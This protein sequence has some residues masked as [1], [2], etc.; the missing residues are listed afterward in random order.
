[1]GKIHENKTYPRSQR[2]NEWLF[3]SYVI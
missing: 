2:W 3:V 1:M